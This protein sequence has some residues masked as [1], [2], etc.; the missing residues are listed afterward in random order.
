MTTKELLNLSSSEISKMK[1][2]ELRKVV[3]TLASTANKRLKRLA[4][5]GISTPS[6]RQVLQVGK[7]STKNKNINQLRAEYIRAKNFLQAK[8][9]TITGFKKF[10][11]EV[12]ANLV[13]KGINISTENLDDVFK[14]YEKLKDM[15]P[16]VAEKNLKYVS[17]QEINELLIGGK[18][19]REILNTLNESLSELYEQEQELDDYAS[20]SDFFTIE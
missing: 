19:E 10:Q 7:I 3:Q 20:I 6:S 1:K 5:K 9:S 8:T 11:K 15:K 18:T 13:Q 4:T 16:E 17:I 12:K 14:I 2:T